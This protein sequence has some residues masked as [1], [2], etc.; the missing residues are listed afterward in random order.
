MCGSLWVRCKVT[1]LFSAASNRCKTFLGLAVFLSTLYSLFL[2]LFHN[3]CLSLSPWNLFQPHSCSSNIIDFFFSA[4]LPFLSFSLACRLLLSQYLSVKK[5][6]LLKNSQ[7]QQQQTWARVFP[8]PEEIDGKH[9]GMR[10]CWQCSLLFTALW[11][12]QEKLM[13]GYAVSWCGV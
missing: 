5:L 4:L 6:P 2:F 7:Q 12:S 1:L 11:N 9:H 10:V 3:V 8:P 13:S